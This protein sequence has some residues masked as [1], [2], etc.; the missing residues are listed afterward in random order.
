MTKRKTKPPKE[1]STEK[2]TEKLRK[3]SENL[4][5]RLIRKRDLELSKAAKAKE[6]EE[7]EEEEEEARIMEEFIAAMDKCD[8][9]AREFYPNEKEWEK[10]IETQRSEMEAYC[11]LKAKSSNRRAKRINNQAVATP[12]DSPRV[13]D[14]T[15]D[16]KHS[17][18]EEPNEVEE[19]EEESKEIED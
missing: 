16:H 7:M 13:E 3:R 10:Y 14:N 11:K 8:Q 18:V 4:R 19:S 6:T 15:S 1:D 9:D 5:K 17:D 2:V 12:K